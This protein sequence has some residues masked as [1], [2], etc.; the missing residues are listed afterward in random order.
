MQHHIQLETFEGPLD[1]LFHLIEKNE[2]DLYDIPMAQLTQQYLE[3]IRKLPPGMEEL[4]EFLV[5]A[6]TL[7]E[8]KS[9]ML[10][11]RYKAEDAEKED[12][13]EALVRQ[14]IAY[15]H[16]QELAAALKS[17]ETSGQRHFKPPEFPLMENVITHT[18]DEWLDE[19][20]P[21]RLWQVF[22]DVMQRQAL[23][24]DT[25]RSKFG[26]VPREQHSIADKIKYIEAYLKDRRRAHLSDLFAACHTRNECI[27]TFLALLEM[28]KIHQ[29]TVRQDNVFGEVEVNLCPI[30]N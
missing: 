5:M 4:S 6:A 24:V 16:C 13:R 12:P 27:A 21:D 26:T 19:V 28:M 8:I 22:A 18:P 29:V 15:K 20:T 1:L 17:Y 30:C 25:V 2:I 11:P 23:K 14:L 9:R 3:A 7:L 10:L